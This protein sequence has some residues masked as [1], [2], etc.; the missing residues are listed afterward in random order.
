MSPDKN[1]EITFPFTHPASEFASPGPTG[2][3]AETHFGALGCCCEMHS[4]PRA[5]QS[6]GGSNNN[7]SLA[8]C[9]ILITSFL[10]GSK[11]ACVDLWAVGTRARIQISH[12]HSYFSF[13]ISLSFAGTALSVWCKKR[14][15]IARWLHKKTLGVANAP[16]IGIID[17]FDSLGRLGCMRCHTL[18][19]RFFWY[20]NSLIRETSGAFQIPSDVRTARDTCNLRG[21]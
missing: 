12:L 15:E 10:S 18:V 9:F 13:L 4:L 1:A 8:A 5:D 21:I 6:A 19:A 20:S 11:F 14:R 7:S 3:L 16:A 17:K 2:V